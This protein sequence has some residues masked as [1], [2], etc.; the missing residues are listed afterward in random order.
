MRTL[1]L[2]ML[3]AL[4]MKGYAADFSFKPTAGKFT[5][6]QA[7]D[8]TPVVKSALNMF[9]ADYS[10]IFGVVPTLV[11][12]KAQATLSIETIADGEWEA[13][14]VQVTDGKLH[15]SGSDAR[16]TAYGILELSRLIGVSP[17]VWWAD[18]TPQQQESYTLPSNYLNKQKPSV[19]YRGIFINDED[20][21]LTPWSWA[22][23]EPSAVKGTIGPK[24]HERIF[25][26]LLRL[27]A[28]TMLPAM[29]D[30][31]IPF[32]LTKGN[33]EMADKYSIVMGTSHCEPLMRNN[34]GEWD[35]SKRGAYNYLTNKA[36]IQSY[37]VE[38]LQE[39]QHSNNYYTIG[40]RGIH[41]GQM[42]GTKNLDEMTAAMQQ[43]IADQRR[44]LTQHIR[45]DITT[46]PQVFVPYKELLDV[47]NNGL[48]V[49]DDVTLMW[50]DDNYGR[51]TRLSNPQEQKRSGGAG[52][53]YH[54]SYWGRPHSYL[55]LCTTPP[56]Q[57]YTEMQ[58]AWQHNARKIWIVNVGDI[59]PGEYDLE[60]FLDMA[61][62]INSITPSTI[63]NHLE[64]WMARTFSPTVSK[65]LA[66]M[67]N[68]YYH[69]ATIRRPEFMGWSRE[70]E[71]G[72]KGG[73]TPVINTEFSSKEIQERL[74][75][76]QQLGARVEAVRKL[77][78]ANLQ[79]AYFQLIAYP[80]QGATA[81][82][83]KWLYA[84]QART[85][86]TLEEAKQFETASTVAYNKITALDR[87]YNYDMQRG[88]WRGMMDMKPG[89]RFVFDAFA[90]PSDFTPQPPAPVVV[91]SR[92]L[93]WNAFEH[94]SK[95]VDGV[96]TTQ[97]LG[98]SKQAVTLPVGKPLTYTIETTEVGEAALWI[99][100]LPTHPAT[101]KELRYE[102]SLD[103]DKPQVVAFNTT[104]RSEQWK[105]NVLR[106]LSLN[107]TM[108]ALPR[109]GKHTIRIKAID[110]EVIVDQLMLDFEPQIPFYRI[111]TNPGK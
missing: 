100:V 101:T 31:S 30:C 55:W 85:A 91:K 81:M 14:C 73:K 97:G 61:W 5:V 103:N 72:I 26:L 95:A 87:H 19:Q 24:T 36:E 108:H 13:F 71:S 102:V 38:R 47:Y 60:F 6:Y 20:W 66:A 54:I 67:M 43:V 53:Y 99:S 105:I 96:Y 90:L 78:P 86:S 12:T 80:V 111:L 89:A 57:I 17:W 59:K 98:Y 44:L 79:D 10:S 58:R 18:V 110:E 32:Y 63:T 92:Y 51:I 106:N 69:L 15:V 88:K 29:H 1:L 82:N 3:L 39:L 41:D 104:G 75:A 49:P 27:R 23:Y 45:P 16:G 62:D 9:I 25:Q 21:G 93:S 11:A 109:P 7:N 83:Q 94:Q 46:I 37:W 8:A 52:V 77:I 56:A 2:T 84:Q 64:A 76:Y 33:K 35:S 48:Q 70:E 68:E 34:V 4:T 42:E 40:M 50:C 22:N 74:K 107:K 65:E 28:N